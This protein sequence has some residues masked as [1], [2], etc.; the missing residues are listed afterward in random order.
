V[1][2]DWLVHATN[3]HLST[4]LRDR[5]FVKQMV[6]ADVLRQ[7]AAEGQGIRVVIVVVDDS[8][9]RKALTPEH[10]QRQSGW[11]VDLLDNY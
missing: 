7:E 1:P 10:A 4:N 9:H 11:L 8:S 2:V 5:V 3:A 6:N